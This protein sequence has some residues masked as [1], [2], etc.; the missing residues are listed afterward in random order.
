[1]N[2]S[3]SAS[4]A[5]AAIPERLSHADLLKNAC[6]LVVDDSRMMRLA[7]VR[8]LNDLGVTH[9]LEARHGLDELNQIRA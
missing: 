2:Q 9:I 7:L 1:M 4:D 6:V 5:T 3:I 8:A